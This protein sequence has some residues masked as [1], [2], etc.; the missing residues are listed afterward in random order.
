[1]SR[2]AELTARRHELIRR[3]AEERL[4]LTGEVRAIAATLSIADRISLL[5]GRMLH[6]PLLAAVGAGAVLLLGPQR[7][8]GYAM[9]AFAVWT[10]A[11]RLL[12]L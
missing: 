11:R 3:S 6:R 2:L 8:I 10:A 12:R 4:Q 9:R 1:V 5:L 7:A